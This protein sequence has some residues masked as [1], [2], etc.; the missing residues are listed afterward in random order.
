MSHDILKVSGNCEM[1]KSRIEKA[2]KSI[3]GV[4][5]AN[6]DVKAKVIH[7]DFDSKTTSK[8]NISKAIAKVGH[9]TELDKASKAAYDNL[10]SCCLYDR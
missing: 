1:C 5:S 6:W 3:K 2:A 7:L 8:S 9:D 10:P 4:Y